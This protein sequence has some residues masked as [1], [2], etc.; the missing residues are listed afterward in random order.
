MFIRAA[1]R[2]DKVAADVGGEL[3]MFPRK[4]AGEVGGCIGLRFGAVEKSG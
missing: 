3:W 2:G 1:E 4:F